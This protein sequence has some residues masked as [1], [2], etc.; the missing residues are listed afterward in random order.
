MLCKGCIWLRDYNS[1][2]SDIE[3]ICSEVSYKKM[4]K[5]LILKK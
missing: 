2:T 1:F 3:V 4:G 5:E